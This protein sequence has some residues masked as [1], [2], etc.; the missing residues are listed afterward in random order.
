MGDM[1][2]VERAYSD[3]PVEYPGRV[4]SVPLAEDT[5]ANSI[6][7]RPGVSRISGPILTNEAAPYTIYEAIADAIEVMAG[8][9]F[10][11]PFTGEH[12]IEYWIWSGS[13]L[14]PAPPEVAE[15]LREQE[16]RERAERRLVRERQQAY[17]QLRWQAFRRFKKRLLSLEFLRIF[18][19]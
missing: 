3:L 4:D 6:V 14:V 16:A 12:D 19:L 10:P 7:G 5:V 9:P 1:D 13:R 8:E 15:R 11:D 18:F 2:D 17:R